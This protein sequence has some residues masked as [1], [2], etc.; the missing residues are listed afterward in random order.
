MTPTAPRGNADDQ[1]RVYYQAPTSA[2]AIKPDPKHETV[3]VLAQ[4]ADDNGGFVRDYST[5]PD[6]H[7]EPSASR[8]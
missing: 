3:N 5:E 7:A 6:D 8:S 4:L 2:P 1:G